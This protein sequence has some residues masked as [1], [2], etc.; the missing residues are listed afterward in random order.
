MT[1]Y[2][3]KA[4]HR[5]GR[6]VMCHLIADTLDELH[7]MARAI[8]CRRTWFQDG[9]HPHYDIPL[10]RRQRALRLGAVEIDRRDLAR[11]LRR[12]GL[13]GLPVCA[14]SR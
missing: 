1:V 13:S 6:M 3:D 14:E 4:R 8:G 7:S 2:V 9:R 12:R 10:F 5:Y 11:F